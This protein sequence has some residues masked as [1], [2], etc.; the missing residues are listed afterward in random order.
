MFIGSEV[1][2]AKGEFDSFKVWL[3][4][5][6]CFFEYVFVPKFPSI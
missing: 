4:R 2:L 3:N 5:K 6:L 1:L